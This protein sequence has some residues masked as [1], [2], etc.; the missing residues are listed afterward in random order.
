M[1]VFETNHNL[2]EGRGSK[3]KLTEGFVQCKDYLTAARR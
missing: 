1:K 2:I 3:H